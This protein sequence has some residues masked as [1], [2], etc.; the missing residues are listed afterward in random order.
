MRIPAREE[1]SRHA[2]LVVLPSAEGRSQLLA[3]V[4]AAGMRPRLMDSLKEGKHALENGGFEVVICE[5]RV[6][7]EMLEETARHAK[8][9]AKRISVIVT[10]RV[11]EWP[12]YLDVLKQGAFDCLPLPSQPAEVKR[13]LGS[14]AADSRRGEGNAGGSDR[15]GT[16]SELA[17]AA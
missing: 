4:A 7:G 15:T 12:E 6:S 5:D 11:G 14:A 8:M 17:A 16:G 10:L 1:Q 9:R 13:I 2:V 3:A